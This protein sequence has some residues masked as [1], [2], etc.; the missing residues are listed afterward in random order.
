MLTQTSQNKCLQQTPNCNTCTNAGQAVVRQC[1]SAGCGF[2]DISYAGAYF[3]SVCGTN[4]G[5][6][7]FE[8]S[9]HTFIAV[10]S[11]A[12]PVPTNAST[13]ATKR[14]EKFFRFARN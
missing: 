5:Y 3:G 9:P 7:D 4:K 12:C 8:A 6:M 11:I 10:P 1:I 2:R 13:T 14:E